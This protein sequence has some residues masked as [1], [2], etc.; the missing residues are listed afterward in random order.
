MD[1]KSCIRRRIES[2]AFDDALVGRH[3]VFIAGPRQVGKT[4]LA[5][6]RLK[7]SG[8]LPLYFDWDDPKTRRSYLRDPRFF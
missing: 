8:C 7:R 5:R 3:M 4:R 2:Y 6:R 1:S